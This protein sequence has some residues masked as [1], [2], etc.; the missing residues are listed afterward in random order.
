[1]HAEVACTGRVARR[2][3][4]GAWEGEDGV[5]FACERARVPFPPDLA[6]AASLACLAYAVD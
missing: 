1:V 5:R 4:R 6:I 2:A 3:S